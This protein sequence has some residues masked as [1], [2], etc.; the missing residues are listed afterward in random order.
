MGDV[1]LSTGGDGF[2]VTTGTTPL[3]RL[4]DRAR[5]L[6]QYHRGDQCAVAH[7]GETRRVER[8]AAV[9]VRRPVD[10]INDDRECSLTGDTGLFAHH[11]IA[12]ANQY[13]TCDVV[14]RDVEVILRRSI[15]RESP[16]PM[17]LD[18]FANLLRAVTQ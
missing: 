7:D 5:R 16:A 13:P 6:T 8:N 4:E 3:L 14:G 12:G 11:S 18:G 9:T 2:A 1:R 10:W 15:P 17:S